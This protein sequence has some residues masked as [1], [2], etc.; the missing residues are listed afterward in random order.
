MESIKPDSSLQPEPACLFNSESF[1]SQKEYPEDEINIQDPITCNTVMHPPEKEKAEN[2][3]VKENNEA[4]YEEVNI[5]HQS[6]KD[7]ATANDTKYDIPLEAEFNDLTD[8]Q[9]EQIYQALYKI[10]SRRK[11]STEH[12][13]QVDTEHDTEPSYEHIDDL[14]I[15]QLKAKK[16]QPL[17]R[18]G[19]HSTEK[20]I[21]KEE[22]TGRQVQEGCNE[23]QEHTI[24]QPLASQNSGYQVHESKFS[25]TP[26]PLPPKKRKFKVQLNT[27]HLG[28]FLIFAHKCRFLNACYPI[29][30][31]NSRH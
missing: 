1:D 10:V 18:K 20:Q 31:L 5:K 22:L 4:V 6:G 14:K 25:D 13:N 27:T 29:A 28:E 15:D 11:G 19:R 21:C 7:A 17:P 26:P 30:C 23:K 9:I 16:P 3:T 24:R 12:A 2:L 8:E